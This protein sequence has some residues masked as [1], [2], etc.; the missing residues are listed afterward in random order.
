MGINEISNA[1]IKQGHTIT[2]RQPVNS[3]INMNSSLSSSG[4]PARSHV[5]TVKS[6]FAS[7]GLTPPN[8]LCKR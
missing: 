8:K 4:S 6:L 2:Y 3:P 1:D 7:F 5:K